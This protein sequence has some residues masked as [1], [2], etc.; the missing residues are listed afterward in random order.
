MSQTRLGSFIE[1]CI[2]VLIGFWINEAR[3]PAKTQPETD[4]HK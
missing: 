4:K 2:N 3:Q 1:S